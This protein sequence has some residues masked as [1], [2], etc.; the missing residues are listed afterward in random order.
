MNRKKAGFL[1]GLTAGLF[2]FLIVAVLLQTSIEP[3][4]SQETKFNGTLEVN[5]YATVYAEPDEVNVVLAVVTEAEN[6][7]D[8]SSNNAEKM[9][10]IYNEL[11]KLKIP[12]KNIKTTGYRIEPIYQWVEEST[13][14][15]KTQKN[16][17]VG[18]RVTN[19]ISVTSE[20]DMAGK[21]IDAA[22]RAGANRIDGITF[23]LKEDTRKKYYDDALRMA[24]QDAKGKAEVVANELGIDSIKPSKIVVEGSY[25]RP[26]PFQALYKSEAGMDASTPVSP[27]DVQISSSVY[28]T[29]EY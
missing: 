7:Q 4:K 27:S 19:K 10:A 24:V 22:T 3:V 2:A 13:G 18:Y 20:P 5:G 26:V 21:I 25:Y 17:I 8:A 1:V 28:I 11:R 9:N 23:G 29:Y 15:T 12:E 14:F 6:A 16:I